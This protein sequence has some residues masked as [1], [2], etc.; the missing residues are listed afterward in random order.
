[1]NNQL[2]DEIEELRREG[3]TLQLHPQ[4]GGWDFVVIEQYSLPNGFNQ[5]SS[6][7]LIK[8]PPNYPLGG[9]DMFWMHPQLLLANGAMPAN[10]SIEQNLG[11]AWLRFS[12]HPHRWNPSSDGLISY[13]KFIDSRLEQKQ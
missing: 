10:T 13:L 8:V 12:W 1:M 6:P 5:K 4:E 7:L 3:F 9:M 11:Q 2:A